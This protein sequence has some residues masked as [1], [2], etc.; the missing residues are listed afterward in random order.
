MNMVTSRDV[1]TVSP[2]KR[3][4]VEDAEAAEA[5]LVRALQL[6]GKICLAKRRKAWPYQVATW[7]TELV[8][9]LED[10]NDLQVTR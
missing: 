5:V 3:I 2:R 7:E 6:L 8:A 10:L 1:D 9:C 4:R